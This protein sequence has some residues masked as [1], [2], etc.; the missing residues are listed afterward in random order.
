MRA[1][2][3]ALAVATAPVQAE[4]ILSAR[5]IGPTDRYDHG[6]L[7]D[8]LEWSG[9][10]VE[11]EASTGRKGGLF[12]ASRKFTF[13]IDLPEDRVFEDTEPRLWDVTGDGSPEVVTILTQV[14]LGAALVVL[15]AVD[16]TVREIASTPHIGRT[17]R[18]L[19]PVGAADLDG[20]GAIEVAF[21]DRPHLARVLRVWRYRD[22][23]FREVAAFEGVT[24]HRIGDS[25]IAGGMRQCDAGPEM[26]MASADWTRIVS[27]T[28]DGSRFARRDL[29]P[30]RG[31]ASFADALNCR[32]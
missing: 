24:N 31:P 25:R 3:L 9:I 11:T 28:F 22:G 29:G 5:Y 27:V 6:I 2:A 10:E 16:G 18:W 15:G 17:H 23:D 12:S 20:D 13:R 8:A 7:G 4:E 32:L 26:I 19:A 21:V 1:L 14:D 30:N